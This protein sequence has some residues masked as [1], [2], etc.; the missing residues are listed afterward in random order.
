[1]FRL[2][3]NIS[4]FLQSPKAGWVVLGLG[5]V[6]RLGYWLIIRDQPLVGDAAEYVKEAEHYYWGFLNRE[7]YW[8]PLLPYWLSIIA[9]LFQWNRDALL[10]SMLPS[11]LLLHFSLWGLARKTVGNIATTLVLLGMALYPEFIVQSVEPESYL[12][13]ATLIT[14]LIWGIYHS[15]Q[16]DKLGWLIPSGIAMGCLILLRPSAW[17]LI[18]MI[19]I[20]LAWGKTEFWKRAV[21]WTT[22][23][24]ILPTLWMSYTEYAYKHKWWINGANA[25][26]FYLGNN[27]STP[28]Y[29]TWYW[30]SHWNPDPQFRAVVDSGWHLLGNELD[31]YYGEKALSHILAEPGTFL[32][33][34]ASRARVFWA[35]DITAGASIQHH[36]GSKSLG[37][38]VS[39]FGAMI[40][41]GVL[42]SFCWTSS[43]NTFRQ[44]SFP[45]WAF[46]LIIVWL[47]PYLLAFSHPSYHLP[48]LPILFLWASGRKW[49]NPFGAAARPTLHWRIL[50]TLIILAVQ[51]EWIIRV[52]LPKT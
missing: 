35:M 42:L 29:E 9:T 27:P 45:R 11:Y 17:L 36:T 39:G 7:P 49:I 14:F 2:P 52:V 20:L 15:L 6:L 43:T 23:S 21:F 34:A 38:A 40:W 28:H 37:M 8:P 16:Q 33:R 24:L 48:I 26:N 10:L 47:I 50:G 1:M 44:S 51:V 25:Y 4:A 5:L 3:P 12:P 22:V 30:G 41:I 13:A 31:E 19:G 32:N 18:P 46:W